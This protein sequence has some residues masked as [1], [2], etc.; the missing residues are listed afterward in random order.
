[1]AGGGGGGGGGQQGAR[2][3][4]GFGNWGGGGLGDWSGWGRGKGTW[5]GGDLRTGTPQ[6]IGEDI[7]APPVAPPAPGTPWGSAIGGH[8]AGE[9]NYPTNAPVGALD[10]RL[11]YGA[12]FGQNPDAPPPPAVGTVPSPVP[13][14]GPGSRP[15]EWE[16]GPGYGRWPGDF[17]GPII[18]DTKPGWMKGSGFG[19][20]YP[21]SGVNPFMLQS[22]MQLLGGR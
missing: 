14:G 20:E 19:M 18:D 3:W 5:E 13:S 16:R 12:G 4:G 15:W 6:R 10:E 1:M 22:I 2:E 11:F 9:W 21:N 7:A 8:Q 17:P